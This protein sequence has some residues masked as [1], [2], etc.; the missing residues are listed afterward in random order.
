MS[1]ISIATAEEIHDVFDLVKEGLL[2]YEDTLHDI[3]DA[4]LKSSI[5]KSHSLAPQFLLKVDNK[6]VGVASLTLTVL[7]W[8]QKPFLTSNMVYVLKEYRSFDTIKQLYD[9]IRK[10]ADL[11]G[12]I[13]LDVFHGADRDDAKIRLSKA[14]NLSILGTS[15][16]YKG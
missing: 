5:I 14:N 9:V 12:L 16:Y 10:F 3:D 15:I 13:Y 6:P 8:S 2:G 11:E 7:P 4:F 1:S